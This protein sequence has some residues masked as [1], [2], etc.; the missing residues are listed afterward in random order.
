MSP[1]A[2]MQKLRAPARASSSAARSTDHPLTR[3]EGS[4]R[5]SGRQRQALNTPPL[6]R[7]KSSQ[8]DST[9]PTSTPHSSSV[10]SPRPRR[11]ISLSG[12]KGLNRVSTARNQSNA[13]ATTSPSTSGSRRSI[14]IA[15]P[16][17]CSTRMRRVSVSN[18]GLVERGLHRLGV[19]VAGVGRA[20]EAIDLGTLRLQNLVMQPRRSVL[21]DLRRPW[22]VE[23]QLHRL[24]VGDPPAGDRQLHLGIAEMGGDV[25]TSVLPVFIGWASG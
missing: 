19:G 15:V 23:R 18:T 22:P 21:A 10:S 17:M 14:E 16:M 11:L 25:L 2:L 12:W 13:A 5:P 1:P 7:R 8:S 9:S 20:G 24:H 3:P 4:S 6:S